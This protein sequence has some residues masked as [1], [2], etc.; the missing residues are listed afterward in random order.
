MAEKGMCAN[1]PCFNRGAQ[2]ERMGGLSL[3]PPYPTDSTR[4]GA[5]WPLRRGEGLLL[6][7]GAP[8]CPHFEKVD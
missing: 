2:G 1:T 4:S 8:Q 7:D 3:P 5:T 6:P